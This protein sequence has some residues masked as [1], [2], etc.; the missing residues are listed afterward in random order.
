MADL[1]KIQAD[2]TEY[3]KSIVTANNVGQCVTAKTLFGEFVEQYG[4]D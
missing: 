4:N 2:F 1:E 3:L